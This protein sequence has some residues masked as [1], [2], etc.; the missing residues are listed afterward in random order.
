MLMYHNVS[1]KGQDFGAIL[2]L[3]ICT[4]ALTPVRQADGPP[5][6]FVSDSPHKVDNY[7]NLLIKHNHYTCIICWLVTQIRLIKVSTK[8]PTLLIAY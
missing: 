8:P 1:Y 5:N 4:P 7:N 6:F 3:K 2:C